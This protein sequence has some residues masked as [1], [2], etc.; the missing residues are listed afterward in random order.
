MTNHFF[1][2]GKERGG[3]SQWVQGKDLLSQEERPDVSAEGV[4]L[5]FPT[6]YTIN[7]RLY[8]RQK[9][10]YHKDKKHNNISHTKI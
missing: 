9:N 2:G 8:S 1:I 3:G 7:L 10:Q 4:R 6:L 5:V